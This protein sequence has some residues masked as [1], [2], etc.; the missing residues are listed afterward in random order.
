VNTVLQLTPLPVPPGYRLPVE[1][2]LERAFDNEDLPRWLA[3]HGST[4]RAV[5]TH[6]LRGMPSDLWPQLPGLQ[7]IANFGA[8]LDLIDLEEA[9]R[10]GVAVTHTPD[11]LT[12]DVADL[13]ITLALAVSRRLLPAD[14]YIRNGQWGKVPFAAGRSTQG[15]RLGILGLGR[16][17]KAIARRAGAFEMHVGYHAR[18]AAESPF[19]FFATPV[20][21]ATWSD[22]LVAAVPG[23][24]ETQHI[25]GREVLDA[26]GPDGIFI[27]IARGSVVDQTAL[28]DA[29]KSGAIAGAGLDVFDHQ[30]IDGAAFAGVPNVVLTP[31]IGSLTTDTRRAM[32]DSVYRNAHALLSGGT[33]HDLAIS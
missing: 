29:L 27:N 30:P 1:L 8:G 13:A 10:R 12:H 33:L 14:T 5:V 26:L 24:T 31:H 18:R 28:I 32:A 23:G 7:L 22:I 15:K 19:A 20:E 3:E 21:L 16:I 2:P 9:A 17:G 6:S 11:L 25:V 4:V